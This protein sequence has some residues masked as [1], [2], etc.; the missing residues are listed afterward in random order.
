M[1][2]IIILLLLYNMLGHQP[3]ICALSYSLVMAYTHRTARYD[4]SLM[5]NGVLGSLVS[6]TCKYSGNCIQN[7]YS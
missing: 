3:D 4:I 2:Y 1:F 5:I 7:K 6:I